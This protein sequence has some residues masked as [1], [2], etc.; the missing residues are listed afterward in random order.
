[1]ICS[2][3]NNPGK[4][5]KKMNKVRSWLLRFTSTFGM[6]VAFSLPALAD[7]CSYIS[8]EQAINAIARLDINEN[9][10]FLC[11]P[12]GEEIPEL[13]KISNLSMEKVDFEDYWQ[14]N[15]NHQGIDLAYVFVDSG[16]ENNFIN[17]AAI[18]DCP[19]QKV[20]PVLPEDKAVEQDRESEVRDYHEGS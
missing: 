1:M 10:Y 17:L 5:N 3:L 8:K 7:Q 12:C 16:V 13:T 15:V 6:C 4:M 18:A 11:E 19:A 9:I 20:S 2:L 14:I